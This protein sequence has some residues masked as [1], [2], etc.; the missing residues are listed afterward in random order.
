MYA[1]N[2]SLEGKPQV[3]AFIEFVLTNPQ[4]IADVGYIKLPESDY[5]LNLAKLEA[6]TD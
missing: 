2:D 4:L 1:A 6:T 3:G 5:E